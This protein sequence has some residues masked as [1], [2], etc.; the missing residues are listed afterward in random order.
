MVLKKEELVFE[1]KKTDDTKCWID[2]EINRINENKKELKIK[3]VELEKNHKNYNVE[4]EITNKLYRNSLKNHKKYNEA[5]IQPYFARIDFKENLRE[6]ESFYIG[7]FGLYDSET[8][9]EIVI[10]WRAP[11]ADLYYSG[12]QGKVIYAAPI[13]KIDGELLLKRKFL[14]KDSQLLDGFDEGINDIILKSGI[15]E[16]EGNTLIDEFLKIN[17]E[18]NMSS[19]LKEVVAT[20]QKEQNDIIRAGIN[21]P[22]I[23]QGSAGSGKTTVALHRLAYLLYRYKDKIQAKDILVIAPNKLFLDYISQVLPSLGAD[24]VKQVTFEEFACEN[25]GIKSEIYSKHK[26]L[27]Y[28]LECKDDDTKTLVFNSSKLKGSAVFR[29]IIDRYVRFLE[30]RDINVE[31]IMINEYV[32]FDKKIIKKLY[33]KDLSYLP[34]NKRKNEME[35]YF[36][37]RIK[38]KVRFICEQIDLKYYDEIYKVK[39]TIKDEEQRRK[40]IIDLYDRRDKDKKFIHDNSENVVKK[41]FKKWKDED[42]IKLYL[43][44][45]NNKESFYEVTDGRIPQILTDYMIKELNDNFNRAVMDSDDLAA[46]IYLKFKIDG[47]EEKYKH[48]VIDEA[49]D[50][51]AFQMEILKSIV[52]N[53][54]LTIVGDIG[55]GIYY[56][57]G[58]EEWDKAINDIFKGDVDYVP[59]TQSYRST[60]EII[61]F[62]NE[63]LKKQKN[64]LKPAVPVL[65]HGNEPEIIEFKTDAQF[66]NELDKVLEYVQSQEKNN[67][68]IIG[69]NL[70]EC[71]KIKDVVDQYSD[72]KWHIIKEADDTLNLER[73]IIPSYMTKG[74][75]FDCSV[76]YN[77]S[78]KNYKNIELDKKLLYVVLTRALHLEYIF[79]KGNK[80]KLLE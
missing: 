5:K 20:I 78:D 21:K 14:F 75:E 13:G 6:K 79:F 53:N 34:L 43:E 39:K 1:K 72:Y 52:S 74:L 2:K 46:L 23:V 48:I 36:K 27:G 50:Y 66:A 10:D 57:K 59:M 80:S 56:Y 22:I 3:L 9:E 42:I 29:I 60:V 11:I 68:A 32:L 40:V 17:L 71:F 73:I 49:Q 45:F 58:I 62:A 35:R 19:K 37:G 65:R 4:F 54:S 70:E 55:Q 31:S 51:S 25:I 44:F 64:N 12:T 30:R 76:I 63:V 24:E 28:I 15:D 18:R 33:A 61:N 67:I 7:K 38:E 69:R 77:C 47:I 41:Y 26:K 16:E 8:E